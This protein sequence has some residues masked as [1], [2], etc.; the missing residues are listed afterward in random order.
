MKLTL[1]YCPGTC[2]LV[3]YVLLTEAGADF[4]SLNVNLG[5]NDQRRPDYL[6]INPKGKVP[7]L[8]IDGEVLTENVAIQIWIAT[9]FPQ[10]RLMPAAPLVYARAVSVMAWCAAAIHPVIRQQARPAVYCDLPDA[11]D[12]VRALGSHSMFDLFAIAETMLQGRDWFF[13]NFTCA[14]AYF[15]W[16]FRRGSMFKTDLSV[17]TNCLAHMRRMEQRVSV[18]AVLA[19]EKRVTEA[20]SKLA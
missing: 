9:Q 3:P 7:A 17:F 19:H 18:Q 4:E 2:S 16:C 10:A 5:K 8:I 6:K 1:A 14:D 11:A 20:F 15:Y 13:E 12:N